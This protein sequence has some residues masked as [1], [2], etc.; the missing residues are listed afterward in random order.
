[1]KLRRI[2][3]NNLHLFNSILA[4]QGFEYVCSLFINEFHFSWSRDPFVM[5]LFT[6]GL[7]MPALLHE[8]DR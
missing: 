8:L 1:M 2:Q 5:D 6:D 7:D 4:V 3:H